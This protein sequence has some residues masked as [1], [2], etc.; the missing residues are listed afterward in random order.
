M[1]GRVIKPQADGYGP[2][3]GD[4]EFPI[5]HRFTA[6]VG[7]N[8]SGKSIL[9]QLAFVHH[10]MTKT[11]SNVCFIPQDRQYISKRTTP[12]IPLNA[13]NLQIYTQCA[14]TPRHSSGITVDIS[15]LYVALLHTDEFVPQINA[16]N[17]Y[18]LRLDFAPLSVKGQQEAIFNNL[19]VSLQGS[20]LRCVLPIIA[21]LTSTTVTTLIIDEP[22]LSLEART[23]RRLKQ[24][25]METDKLVIVG[26]K[27]HLFLNRKELNANHI[28]NVDGD[29]L[30]LTRLED[31]SELIDL[32]YNLLGNS[33]EDLFFPN[34][35][36]LVGC[37]SCQVI[38]EKCAELLKLPKDQV[39]VLSVS[40]LDDV[41]A[42]LQAVEDTLRPLI[43]NTSPYAGRVVVLLDDAANKQQKARVAD[44]KKVIQERCFVLDRDSI[45]EYL[46]QYLYEKCGRNKKDDLLEIAAAKEEKKFKPD[47]GLLR[48]KKIKREIALSITEVLEKRDLDNIGIIR[49]SVT[50]AA[51]FL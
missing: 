42:S 27:S 21:A 37:S 19:N 31:K 11:A 1:P 44:M 8:N 48:L 45:E 16:L 18:L 9:L 39:K 33:L 2:I 41:K 20:G 26:T 46:P 49:D 29:V 3:R 50:K 35:F 4:F 38:C 36:L 43:I 15:E 28:F 32:T 23:Q 6:I 34:N 40:A 7:K 14:N 30:K 13:L 47:T 24:L 51:D 5:H 17:E 12:N 25:L 22:E 10:V